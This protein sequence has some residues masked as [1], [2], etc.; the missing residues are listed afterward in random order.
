MSRNPSRSPR[1]SFLGATLAAL[2]VALLCATTAFA[3]DAADFDKTCAPCKDFDQFANGGWTARTKLPPG[4]TNYGAF[5]E[6]YDRNE[7]VLRKI[8]DKVAMDKSAAAGSDRAR[9]RDYYSSCMDSAGAEAAGGKPIAGPLADVDGMTSVQDLGRQLGWMHAN[10]IGG[11][12][13]FY[14]A[15]DPKQSENVIAHLGQGGLGL[16]DRDF[17]TRTDSASVATRATYVHVTANLL[18]LAGEDAAA[19]QKHADAVMALETALAQASMTNVQRRDPKATYHKMAWDSLALLAPAFHWDDYLLKRNVHPAVVNVTQPDFVRAVNGLLGTTPLETWK[20][21]LKVRI[22]HDASPILSS[23]YVKEWFA[24]RQALS[25]AKEMLPRW[26]RC[27]AETDGQLGEILGKEYL[28]V[29]FTPADKARMDTMVKNLRA[30]LGERIQVATWMGDSTRQ[31]AAGKLAAYDQHIGYPDTWKDYAAVKIQ[32]GQHYANR[33]ATRAF[34]SARTMAKVGKPVDRGEW[35][36]TPPTVNAYYSASLNS[37]NFPAG[38]LQPPFFDTKADDAT[39]Y[40]AI[41]AVIGHEMGH[42]FDDRGRQFDP[43]GNLRDWWTPADVDRYK[44]QADRVRAQFDGYTVIDTLHVNGSLTLGEN[45]ADLGG[46]AVAYAAM[47]KAYASQPRKP[48]DGFTPEQRFFLG[49]ARVWRNLQ[50]DADL[51]TQIQTDPHSPAKWRINGP[52]SNLPEFKAA[53]GCKDGDAMVR[54]E[55]ARAKIW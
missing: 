11:V 41:G 14:S 6:L 23:D 5:D 52:L 3:G 50:T 35:N 44:V 29:A 19:A 26:K 2:A 13:G 9:L 8:L 51:R 53:W 43:K 10:G 21:Y 48:I 38:I 45:L 30:A 17:Y 7:A 15:Q 33:L 31:A 12:F 24:L 49:W 46:L 20:E 47:E 32:P 39:N 37:I 25:G 42:G 16:P 40:G 22:L 36:M 28:K 54:T 55:S 34:E 18:K 4:Y 1:H 27:I